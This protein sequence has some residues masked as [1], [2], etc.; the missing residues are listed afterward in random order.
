MPVRVYANFDHGFEPGPQPK[1]ALRVGH[2]AEIT[3]T[4]SGIFVLFA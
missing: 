1:D 2:L 3:E 4:E